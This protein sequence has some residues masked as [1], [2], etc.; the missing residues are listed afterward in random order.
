[1]D[2]ISNVQFYKYMKFLGYS[3]I[4]TKESLPYYQNIKNKRVYYF[5]RLTTAISSK[6]SLVVF[7]D[8]STIAENNFKKKGWAAYGRISTKEKKFVYNKT[9]ILV[10]ISND[11]VIN[12]QLFKDN[13]F[14]KD[15]V[16]FLYESLIKNNIRSNY[17]DVTLVLDNARLHKT[18]L[19]KLFISAYDI[20]ILYTVKRHSNF[21][22][23]EYVFRYIKKSLKRSHTIL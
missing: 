17:A 4:Q 9:H 23:V 21:N 2:P 10:L 5:D 6:D 3:Y 12:F 11:K 15:V 1:M 19:F 18:E 14:S 7:F 8:S 20:K 16:L 13:V 22:P